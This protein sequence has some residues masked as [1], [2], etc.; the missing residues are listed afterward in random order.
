MVDWGMTLAPTKL[1]LS[2]E[3]PQVA[4]LLHSLQMASEVERYSGLS[5]WLNEFM[6]ALSPE[7]RDDLEVVC[8]TIP[9]R[10]A[11]DYRHKTFSEFLKE[12]KNYPAE[13]LIQEATYWMK[14]KKQFHDNVLSDPMSFVEFM[15]LVYEEKGV[16]D[17]DE[18]DLQR[19]FS[20][21]SK[22]EEL[23]ALMITFLTNMWDKHLRFEWKRKEEELRECVDVLSKFDYSNLSIHEIVETVTNRDLRGREYFEAE[24]EK[25][26]HLI[27]VPT[28]HLGPYVSW[29]SDNKTGAD[30]VLFGARVPANM[31]KNS[32][33][34]VRA[35][36]LVRLNALAD[37]TRIR[38]LEMLAKEPEICAQD[39][40]NVLELSQSSASRHL[41]QLTA[42]GFVTERR[43]DVAKCYTLNRDRVKD[44]AH[45][46]TQ[47]AE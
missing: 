43:R 16:T 22:P 18:K 27:F 40:I 13:N 35:D 8:S 4:I 3:M 1:K 33:A 14:E 24:M 10:F 32:S 36:L 42:S 23:K 6:D 11:F 30:L 46:L 12:L 19:V 37:E 21:Y 25:A 31:N 38:M 44:L 28:P 15:R 47:L 5:P 17:I 34:L 20:F 39:F 7:E 26:T 9:D 2:F 45:I 41:R 29:I